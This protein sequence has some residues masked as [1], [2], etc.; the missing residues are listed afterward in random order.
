MKKVI[1]STLG[2]A[3][4]FFTVSATLSSCSKENVETKVSN[5]DQVLE[6][7]TVLDRMA[8]EMR[9]PDLIFSITE[10]DQAM[11]G[12]H[13][14]LVASRDAC[15]P[16]CLKRKVGGNASEYRANIV[17]VLEYLSIFGSEVETY[18]P[19]D[20]NGDNF[21]NMSDVL[22]ILAS[23][24]NEFETVPLSAVDAVGGEISG[25]GELALYPDELIVNGEILTPISLFKGSNCFVQDYESD[26]YN[27][28]F[29]Y[30]QTMLS[31]ATSGGTIKYFHIN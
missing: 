15:E 28:E 12:N 16:F 6:I 22:V 14:A 26:E 29:C 7:K 19:R 25:S 8:I 2:L 23:F 20:T 30:N 3:L 1:F 17:T 10:I 21:I 13:P 31:F 5:P 4:T 9:A 27:A 24:G 18:D 11:Q